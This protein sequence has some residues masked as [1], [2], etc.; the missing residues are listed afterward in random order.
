MT[1][2][3]NPENFRA[4]REIFRPA[5]KLIFGRLQN[6]TA[7][8]TANNT[9]TRLSP[10]IAPDAAGVSHASMLV[11][12]RR[13]MQRTRAPNAM[14]ALMDAG[15]T[16]EIPRPAGDGRYFFAGSGRILSPIDS[17]IPLA[18]AMDTRIN[19]S[20]GSAPMPRVSARDTAAQT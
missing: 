4:E 3:S 15:N 17:T 18:N 2:F 11:N 16:I 1:G 13:R 5:P 20:C 7:V 10:A 9:P 8:N 19:A 14:V 6:P 12:L